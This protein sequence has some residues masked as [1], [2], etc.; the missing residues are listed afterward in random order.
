M[1]QRMLDYK[2]LAALPAV[3]LPLASAA[4]DIQVFQTDQYVGGIGSGA[5]FHSLDGAVAF[6][7]SGTGRWYQFSDWSKYTMWVSQADGVVVSSTDN[8][9]I[10]V[11]RLASGDMISGGG[12]STGSRIDIFSTN[13][14]RSQGYFHKYG[15]FNS[16]DLDSG[17]I[18]FSF[19]TAAGS[20]RF[21][22][23]EVEEVKSK[24]FKVVRWAYEDSGAGIEAG[25]TLGVPAPGVAGL[26]ALAAG[27]AGVRRKRSS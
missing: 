12:L 9:K 6:A 22:W 2:H 17:F 16:T 3:A 23:A 13:H 24:S 15:N 14:N 4:A 7:G 11:A 8:G 19:E 20:T 1:S 21:G 25:Q 10:M 26:F 18:G 5:A 27:A